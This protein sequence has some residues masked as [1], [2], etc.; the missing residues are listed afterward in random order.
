MSGK[1]VVQVY[2]SLPGGTLEKEAHRLA[3]Y[4]KTA[5]LKPGETEEV[6][7]EVTVDALTSY[8]EES[9]AWILEKGFY[10]IWIGNSLA[11]AKL[12][13]GMKLDATVTKRQVKNLFP[14]KQDLE[15]I[16]Q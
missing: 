7:M 13:G 16:V 15:E 9:A 4:A 12:C 2:A 3:A 8:D 11:S 6:T 1:E 10:G 14:L 5:E